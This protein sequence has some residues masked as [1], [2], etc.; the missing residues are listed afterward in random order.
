MVLKLFKEKADIRTQ[1]ACECYNCQKKGHLI[2]FVQCARPSAFKH[3]LHNEKQIVNVLI[4][5]FPLNYFSSIAT[6]EF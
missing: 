1:I 3:E 6:L 2:K 4:F 5:L